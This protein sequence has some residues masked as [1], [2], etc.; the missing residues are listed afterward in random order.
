[1]GKHIKSFHERDR[2]ALCSLARTGILYREDFYSM[3][4]TKS[5]LYKYDEKKEGLTE[6]HF[7]KDGKEYYTLTEKGKKFVEDKWGVQPYTH[8]P[9]M[10]NHDKGLRDKYMSLTPEQRETVK[11]ERE[12]QNDL[13]NNIQDWKNSGDEELV[14]KAYEMEDNWSRGI[15]S[16]PD[17][18]YES[19]PGVTVFYEVI[20]KNYTEEEISAKFE[21]ADAFSCQL[22]WSRV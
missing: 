14:N 18:T 2:V 4:I 7:A 1:M 19:S 11:T 5:R 21:M 15:Y 8:R 10:Y 3:D 12:F 13:R 9:G 17:F 6:R 20:S 22:E 16:S